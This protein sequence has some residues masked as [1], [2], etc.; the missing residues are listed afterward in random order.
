MLSLALAFKFI[1]V[2]IGFILYSGPLVV[3]V[4]AAFYEL[5]INKKGLCL[6]SY[7]KFWF[8]GFAAPLY[9]SQKV[10]L[11]LSILIYIGFWQI[12]F[13]SS[14]EIANCMEQGDHKT[15]TIATLPQTDESIEL[16]ALEKL[17]ARN[18]ELENLILEKK[19][20]I[21][22]LQSKVDNLLKTKNETDKNVNALMAEM[23]RYLD[24]LASLKEKLKTSE[25]ER[26]LLTKRIE[27]LTIANM[28]VA[29]D[30]AFFKPLVNL[31]DQ[32]IAELNHLL[33]EQAKTVANYQHIITLNHK[34]DLDNTWIWLTVK[35]I[36]LH[37]KHQNQLM[38]MG[39]LHCGVA[40][41]GGA[42][43]YKMFCG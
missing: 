37:D 17:N 20:T 14:L 13:S 4:A 3:V 31:R 38:L 5:I 7:I 42:I 19:K 32:K 26:I 15:E 11:L 40:L 43:I 21:E 1:L 22:L 23:S 12:F 36:H 28:N 6:Y 41:V 34:R 9:L 16:T 33:D 8:L 10:I 35:E 39:A 25:N 27:S 30:I 24:S 2:F 18:K 29:N